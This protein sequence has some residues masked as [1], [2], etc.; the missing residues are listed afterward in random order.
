MEQARIAEPEHHPTIL[1]TYPNPNPHPN[2]FPNQQNVRD[3]GGY[4]HG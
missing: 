3:G 2:P 1:H 4:S